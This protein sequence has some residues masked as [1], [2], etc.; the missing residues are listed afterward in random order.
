[1]MIK[2]KGLMK[3][4]LTVSVD[5]NKIREKN[6]KDKTLFIHEHLI[7]LILN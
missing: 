2:I 3:P 7:S 1:M 5:L 6:K 4:E